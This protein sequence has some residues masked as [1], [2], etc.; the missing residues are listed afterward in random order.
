MKKRVPVSKIM[1]TNLITLQPSQSLSDA[2]KLFEDYHIRHIPV[3]E[4][5]RLTGIISRS[6]LL[7]ISITDLDENG[8][9]IESAVFDV[10]TIPQ[11]MTKNPITVN[12]DTTIRETARIL[13]LHSFNALPITSQGELVGI[14]TS[15]DLIGYL[16]DQY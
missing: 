11:V 6:D 2:E 7:K 5:K 16:L 15:T 13:S 4:G 10:Y 14:V 1:S 8:N 9:T 3:V 12:A